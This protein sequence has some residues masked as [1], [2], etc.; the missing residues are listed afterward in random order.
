MRI[1]R[2][3]RDAQIAA[4]VRCYRRQAAEISAAKGWA[5]TDPSPETVAREVL[6]AMAG[7]DFDNLSPRQWSAAVGEAARELA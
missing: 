5:V 3:D 7:D 4:R 2:R 6:E 1:N